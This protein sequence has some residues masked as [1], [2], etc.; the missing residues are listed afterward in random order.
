MARRHRF[1]FA[2]L[3]QHVVQRGNNRMDIFRSSD[4]Y[5]VLAAILAN[6]SAI[7]GMDVNAYVFMHNHF[8]LLVTPQSATAV[9]RAMHRVGGQYARYFNDRYTRTGTAFEGRYRCTVVDTERYWYSCMRYVELNPV[10]AGFV[11]HP[12]A[13]SWSSYAHHAHGLADPLVTLHPL[14]L[15]LGRS[16]NERQQCWQRHCAE[17][18]AEE[19]LRQLRPVLHAGGILGTLVLPDDG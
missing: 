3:S 12:H 10:R 4:D 6:A 15:A 14:Y 16:P 11:A 13:Y 9:E 19:D 8:H 18:L 2:G 5:V 17:G 1:R 7:T